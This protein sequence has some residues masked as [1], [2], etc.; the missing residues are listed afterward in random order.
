MRIAYRADAT[1][2]ACWWVEENP[3]PRKQKI[4][5]TKRLD[6]CSGSRVSA[7]LVVVDKSPTHSF[8]MFET[9]ER[10]LCR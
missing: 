8:Q 3:A 5:A 7:K 1:A 4:T 9:I 2:A 10:R 6:S